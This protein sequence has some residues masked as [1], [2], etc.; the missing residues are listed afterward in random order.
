[1]SYGNPLAWCI[2]VKAQVLL[3]VAFIS[4]SY[5]SEVPVRRRALAAEDFV[6][7]V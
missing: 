3:L 7:T 6:T 2:V 4:E 5:L 1:M